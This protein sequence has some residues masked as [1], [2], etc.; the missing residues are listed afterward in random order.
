MGIQKPARPYT[1]EPP[2]ASEEELKSF[3][4]R[5]E[6]QIKAQCFILSFRNIECASD[7]FAQAYTR[8]AQYLKGPRKKRP[9]SKRQRRPIERP[10]AMLRTIVT[11]LVIDCHRDQEHR[12]RGEQLAALLQINYTESLTPDTALENAE[13]IGLLKAAVDRLDPRSAAIIRGLFFGGRTQ[14]EIGK[15]LGLAESTMSE[16]KA[17]ALKKLRAVLI[18]DNYPWSRQ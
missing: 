16:A 10:W 18:K 4:E 15:E 11:R 3:F 1:V 9:W 2:I 6:R 5:N 17:A 14:S 13:E 8:R 12:E 7:A